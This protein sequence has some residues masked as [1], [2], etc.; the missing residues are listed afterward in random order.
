MELELWD[1][2]KDDPHTIQNLLQLFFVVRKVQEF[3]E[4]PLE[5][6]YMFLLTVTN[7]YCFNISFYCRLQKTAVS[8]YSGPLPRRVNIITLLLEVD[9]GLLTNFF[10]SELNFVIK[11]KQ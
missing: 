5:R 3:K 6:I 2:I 8:H 4:E 11:I 7:K 9:A 10:I 1:Y